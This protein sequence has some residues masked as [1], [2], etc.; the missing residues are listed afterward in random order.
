[1][2]GSLSHPCVPFT[3]PKTPS[4]A[5]FQACRPSLVMRDRATHQA[6]LL[7]AGVDADGEDDL[8]G[9]VVDA[10]GT[11]TVGSG[12]RGPAVVVVHVD[13]EV[14]MPWVD[15]L[16]EHMGAVVQKGVGGAVEGG[17]VRVPPASAGAC[18]T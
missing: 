6:L 16:H 2:F 17:V 13:A 10:E 11:G 18:G 8:C 12:C 9:L 1:M 7:P 5:D 15:L 3:L 14:S 4:G